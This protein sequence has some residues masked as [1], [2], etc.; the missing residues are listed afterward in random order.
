MPRFQFTIRRMM[1][2]VAIVGLMLGAWAGVEYRRMDFHRRSSVH[3]DRI[4]G[5]GTQTG[6]GN[7]RSVRSGDGL[8]D[9]FVESVVLRH[10]RLSMG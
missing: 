10:R 2:V 9:G 4:V 8:E 7:E 6:Q 3:H 5:L 1:I